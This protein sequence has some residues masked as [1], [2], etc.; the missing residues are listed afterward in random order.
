MSRIPIDQAV[1]DAAKEDFERSLALEAAAGTGKTG[2]LSRRVV[3]AIALGRVRMH[4]VA[5]ITFTRKAA[6]ELQVR[7][8]KQLR[9]QLEETSDPAVVDRLWAGLAELEQASISTIHGFTIQIASYPCN[10]PPRAS[11]FTVRV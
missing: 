4:Q 6:G 2:A 3:S 10:T 8:R 11:L 9:S 5:A 1:R 7:I